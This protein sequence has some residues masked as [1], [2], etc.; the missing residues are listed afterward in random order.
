VSP[1]SRFALVI[2]DCDG[3]LVDSERISNRVFA[4]SLAAEGLPLTP[5]ETMRRYMGRSMASC[6]TLIE[7]ELGRRLDD[8]FFAEV[9]ARTFQAFHRELRAVDGIAEALERIATPVCVASSGE[10]EKMRTTLGLTGLLPR[11]EGRLFSATDVARGKPAPDLFLHAA[12]RMG[13]DPAR[14]AV[15]EDSPLGVEAAVAAGMTPFGY[16]WHEDPA[17]LSDAGARVFDRMA[18]LPGLLTDP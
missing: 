17:A 8:A 10:H 6:R 14:C 2:F 7:A 3:V 1:S 4:E 5:A 16:A 9:Q 11:F 12:A 15:V 13:A 18:T